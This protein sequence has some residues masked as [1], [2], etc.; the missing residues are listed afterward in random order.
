[1]CECQV[2]VVEGEECQQSDLV[3]QLQD[4]DGVE[5]EVCECEKEEE[6]TEENLVCDLQIDEDGNE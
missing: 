5:M 4:V 3:C 1:M 6:C 2:S